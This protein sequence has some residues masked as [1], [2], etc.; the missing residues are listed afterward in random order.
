VARRSSPCLEIGQS[1]VEFALVLP[2]LVIV[3]WLGVE[4]VLLVRDQTLV[5]HAAREAARVAAV[6]GSESEAQQAATTRS[7]LD[8]N[9]HVVINASNGIAEVTVTL[10]EGNRLPL[11][12]RIAPGLAL[13][14]VVAMRIE[15]PG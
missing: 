7:G 14:S 3:M 4:S 10:V 5:T 12:G 15:T 2:I 1:T 6:G 8:R 11:I 9:L 13:H